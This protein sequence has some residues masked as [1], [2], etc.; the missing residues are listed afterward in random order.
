M[1]V[2]GLYRF[3]ANE[4]YAFSVWAPNMNDTATL[5][6]LSYN[7]GFEAKN[8]KYG[9]GSNV[10]KNTRAYYGI[11]NSNPT[12]A[13]VD[14]NINDWG[15]N[16]VTQYGMATHDSRKYY[17]ASAFKGSDAVYVTYRA[18]TS[19]YITESTNWWESTN[20]EMHTSAGQIYANAAGVKQHITDLSFTQYREGKTQDY[21]ITVE[22]KI[23]Y[24]VWGGTNS[25]T[26]I[27]M[28]FAFKSN[29]PAQLNFIND[30]MSWWCGMNW[31][32]KTVTTTGLN[33]ARETTPT[34][35]VIK[36]T[37]T[38]ADPFVLVANNKYYMYGTNGSVNQGFK[39]Y[40]SEDMTNWRLPKAAD[41]TAEG[42]TPKTEQNSGYCFHVN[43]SKAVGTTDLWAAEVKYNPTTKK[44]VMFYS[45]GKYFGDVKVP[46]SGV[47]TS[48]SPLGPFIDANGGTP[49]IYPTENN[50]ASIDASCFLD[51]DG[52]AYMF[53]SKDCSHNYIENYYNGQGCNVSQTWGVAL[54]STWTKIVGTPVQISTPDQPWEFADGGT[55]FWNEGP[56]VFKENGKYY[57]TY[58]ANNYGGTNY[59][60]GLAI[61]TS[62]LGT[63]KK[64]AGNP[65]VTQDPGKTVGTGH[66]MMF[67]DL[68]GKKWYTFH[69]YVDLENVAYNKQRVALFARI[70]FHNGVPT[71]E[72]KNW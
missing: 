59:G 55:W 34:E 29:D 42:I 8:A 49:M 21:I 52:K 57:L 6:I 43:W 13:T 3:F 18:R 5:G 58:S 66:G 4:K 51:T 39:V 23:P 46:K 22:A 9:V 25:S 56:F 64:Y 16:I 37:M 61:A 50:V 45:G 26:S 60:V 10:L 28:S 32:N 67:T 24:S 53:Y 15:E 33:I 36:T 65:I 14:G 70:W 40:I 17:F 31:G 1:R 35:K 7:M 47:A 30:D 19:N 11:T 27:S 62:P 68:S 69:T 44:Y 12:S 72:Y 63:Y 71:I 20:I 48:D 38:C 41:F 54:D 2:E